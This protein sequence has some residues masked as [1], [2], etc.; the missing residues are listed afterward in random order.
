MMTEDHSPHLTQNRK[1]ESNAASVI[2]P[3]GPN[4]HW[5]ITKK[6]PTTWR[7]RMQRAEEGPRVTS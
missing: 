6:E 4:H 2:M 3:T 7:K 1:D 5:G